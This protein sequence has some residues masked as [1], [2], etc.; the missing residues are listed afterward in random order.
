MPEKKSS[1]TDDILD[2]KK[3]TNSDDFDYENCEITSTPLEK[4]R[5]T[6]AGK[7]LIHQAGLD[8]SPIQKL[9]DVLF[10]LGVIKKTSQLLRQYKNINKK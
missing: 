10:L 6:I 5:C 2:S 8:N 1:K 4:I 7:N 9:P 3:D